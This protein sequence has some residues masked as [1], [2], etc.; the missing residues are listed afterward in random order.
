M[1]ALI[2][3]L[4]LA[5]LSLSACSSGQYHSITPAPAPTIDSATVTAGRP[6]LPDSVTQPIDM[7]QLQ[8][9]QASSGIFSIQVP[10]SWT[11]EDQ[12]SASE[13]LVRFSDA[14]DNSMVIADILARPP[15]QSSAQLSELLRAY[16]QQAY[17]MQPGF[18]Q[19]AAQPQKDSSILIVWGYTIRANTGRALRLLGN[20]FIEQHD[21]LVSILTI[22]LP[23][24]QFPRLA[25]AIDTILNSYHV[26]PAAAA[27]LAVMPAPT[28]APTLQLAVAPGTPRPVD[29]RLVPVAIGALARY[30]YPHGL[31]SIRIPQSWQ[32]HNTSKPGEAILSWQDQANNAVISVDVFGSD[33]Q[34][35][36]SLISMLQGSLKES[37]SSQPAFTLHSTLV[38]ADGSIR[39]VWSYIATADTHIQARML[40]NSFIEQHG[41]H[42]SIL[43]IMVPDTQFER[44]HPILNTILNSYVLDPAAALP[45]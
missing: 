32:A 20:S 2:W 39:V 41:T 37:F 26:E 5:V 44:L 4:V 33:P 8:Q 31:F 22:G 27:A 30:S 12:S 24:E 6:A 21:G 17:G 45:S 42:I 16:L 40:G 3:P 1:R 15:G 25:T 23:A 28:P 19:E 13:V 11:I 43:T 34:A 14:H 36:S 35:E 7:G 18:V 38:Q 29:D 9:Y 10:A